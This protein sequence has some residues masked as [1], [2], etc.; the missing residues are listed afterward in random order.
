MLSHVNSTRC[1][2]SSLA[3]KFVAPLQTMSPSHNIEG[4]LGKCFSTYLTCLIAAHSE[5]ILQRH[6][7]VL[8]LLPIGQFQVKFS[9]TLA[10]QFIPSGEIFTVEIKCDVP[11]LP[12]LLQRFW[13]ICM[14]CY[15]T[16]LSRVKSTSH[17]LTDTDTSLF[18]DPEQV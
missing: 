13:N 12:C 5:L 6:W 8:H 11:R 15:F 4:Q 1:L 14:S 2:F 18:S 10:G 9:F 17:S 16:F 3:A 7:M